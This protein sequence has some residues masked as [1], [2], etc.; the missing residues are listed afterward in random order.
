MRIRLSIPDDLFSEAQRL[1]GE[2]SFSEFTS[3]AIRSKIEQIKREFL[4][5]EMEEGYDAEAKRPSLDPDWKCV[6]V[7]SL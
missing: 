7:E 4:A 6:E 3:A 5:R 1:A 2:R